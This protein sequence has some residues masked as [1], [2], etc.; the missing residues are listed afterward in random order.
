MDRLADLLEKYPNVIVIEDG[1]YEAFAFDYK[2]FTLPRMGKTKNMWNRTVSI[3]SAG[4]LFSATGIRIGWTIAP[5]HL[6]KYIFG[7]H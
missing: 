3:C 6:T 5:E 1:V 7:F 4:K 2:P